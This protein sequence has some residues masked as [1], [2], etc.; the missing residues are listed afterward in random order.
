MPTTSTSCYTITSNSTNTTAGPLCGWVHAADYWGTSGTVTGPA[1]TTTSSNTLAYDNCIWVER[2]PAWVE[3]GL[4]SPNETRSITLTPEQIERAARAQE[5]A[6]REAEARKADHAEAVERSK[7]LLLSY[8]TADQRAT[9]KKHGWFVVEGGK[10]KNRY[11]VRTNTCAGNIEVLAAND[12]NKVTHRFCAHC[13]YSAIA[14]Y[15]HYLAQKLMIECAEE[16]FLK[17]ANRRAA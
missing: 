1:S 15:D 3:T 13:D 12:N 5:Q 10:S 4:L 2:G 9:F 16:E 8:L 6:H 14:E 17:I 11:R 7:E